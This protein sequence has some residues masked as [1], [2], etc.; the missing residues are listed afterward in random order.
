MISEEYADL[1]A[2][3]TASDGTYTPTELVSAACAAG[4]TYL[5]V[6]DH[7]TLGGLPE[8]LAAARAAG[9][10]LLPGVELSAEGAPGKCHLLGLGIDPDHADLR[11][12]LA[13]LSA[14]RRARN[15]RMADRLTALGMSIT[16][17]EVTAAAPTGANV[18]RPHFAQTMVAKGY[19]RDTQEA[20]NRYL[21]DEA[22][23]YVEKQTLSPGEAIRL[24]HDAGGLCFIAHPGLL[25][26]A[27][28]ET[29][30]TRMSALKAL[31]LDGLEAYYSAYSPAETERFLRLAAKLGMLVTGGSDF[32]GANRPEVRI[33][34]VI[35]GAPLPASRL[36]QDLLARAI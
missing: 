25:K 36:P 18:G 17:E 20:F 5:A 15:A 8:A 34:Q 3:T 16:L 33:G 26:L 24:I 30:E 4:L 13:T 21:G 22:A 35:D 19:V 9:I 2:H 32:H 1:H 29:Q 11:D 10:R 14:N 28:H 12:T 27:Q 7:D 23:A 31:G 6:T